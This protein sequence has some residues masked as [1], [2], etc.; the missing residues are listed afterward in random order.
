VWKRR[1][2]RGKKNETPCDGSV[3]DA[4]DAQPQKTF[5]TQPRKSWTGRA[6]SFVKRI[7]RDAQ[8]LRS[9]PVSV[10]V[11]KEDGANL[12]SLEHT[13]GGKDDGK[14]GETREKGSNSG[15]EARGGVASGEGN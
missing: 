13:G 6:T 8:A 2:L 10:K 7:P 9:R 3:R 11:E 4:L 15:K 14:K 5:S 12:L 1:R